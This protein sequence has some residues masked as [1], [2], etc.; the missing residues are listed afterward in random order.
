ML[1]KFKEVEALVPILLGES[2]EISKTIKGFFTNTRK[3]LEEYINGAEKGGTNNPPDFSKLESKFE[4]SFKK[5]I[6]K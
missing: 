1:A 5:F 4:E 2:T 6:S 3:T